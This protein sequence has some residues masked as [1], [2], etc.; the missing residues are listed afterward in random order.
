MKTVITGR[1]VNLKDNYLSF[2]ELNLSINLDALTDKGALVK[3]YRDAIVEKSSDRRGDNS[4]RRNGLSRRGNYFRNEWGAWY[5]YGGAVK[6][7]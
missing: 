3:K 7:I 5:S 1:K 6:A 2:E 4:S